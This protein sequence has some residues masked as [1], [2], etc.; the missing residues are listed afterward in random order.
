MA[1]SGQVIRKEALDVRQ[2]YYDMRKQ[3]QRNVEGKGENS[4]G[5][6]VNGISKDGECE[7]T[8]VCPWA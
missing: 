3:E 6:V 7:V 2:H 5:N 1:G 4:R 8:S